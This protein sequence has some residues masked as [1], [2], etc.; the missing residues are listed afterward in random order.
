[1]EVRINIIIII[2]LISSNNVN[3]SLLG[4]VTRGIVDTALNISNNL[5]VGLPA[6]VAMNAL[7][8]GCKNKFS[9]FFTFKADS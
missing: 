4:R 2:L 7:N 6:V 1:M 8:I 9:F 3:A 5:V